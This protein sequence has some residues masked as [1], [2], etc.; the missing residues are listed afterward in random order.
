MKDPITSNRAVYS[1]A[2]SGNNIFAGS[3]TGVFV[4][5]DMGTKWTLVNSGL[6]CSSANRVGA[7]YSLAVSGSTVFAGCTFGVYLSAN[8]GKNWLSVNDCLT[9]ERTHS[10]A[11]NEDY[12]FSGTFFK[13]V[14][15]YPLSDITRSTDNPA[16]NAAHSDGFKI[17]FPSTTGSKASVVFSLPR[18]E[19]VSVTIYNLSG[20]SILSL[21]D[22]QFESGSQ[23]ISLDTRS[24]APGCYWIKMRSGTNTCVKNFTLIR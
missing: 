3:D 6:S 9:G 20:H 7:I 19:Q 17:F 12:I 22:N 15:R 5:A 21:A 16:R 1:L 8:Y 13:S 4:S 18:P 10:L 2:V 14:W 11:V 24:L 23:S